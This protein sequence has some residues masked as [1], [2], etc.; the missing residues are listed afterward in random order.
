M[1]SKISIGHLKWQENIPSDYLSINYFYQFSNTF[2]ALTI[3]FFP[4]FCYKHRN[5]VR[6]KLLADCVCVNYP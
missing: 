6:K 1:D 4:D 2:S 3:D 5:S